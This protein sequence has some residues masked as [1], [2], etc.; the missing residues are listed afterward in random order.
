MWFVNR[1]INRETGDF[2]HALMTF[3]VSWTLPEKGAFDVKAPGERLYGHNLPPSSSN[4][5]TQPSER[6]FTRFQHNPLEFW[7]LSRKSENI[8]RNR[9]SLVCAQRVWVKYETFPL[10]KRTIFKEREKDLFMKYRK[11]Y[12]IWPVKDTKSRQWN[13]KGEVLKYLENSKLWPWNERSEQN[14]GF[15]IND[16]DKTIPSR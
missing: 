10:L 12:L 3:W 13:E 15:L 16:W 2:S 8:Q 14:N 7:Y 11:S 5:V 9:L 4:T 6:P 1:G